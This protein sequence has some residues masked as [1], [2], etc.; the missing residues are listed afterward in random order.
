[1]IRLAVAGALGRMGR[2]VI[3]RAAQD[4]RFTLT[5]ALVAELPKQLDGAIPYETN[6]AKP[7]DVLIDFTDARGTRSWLPV[8]AERRIAMVIGTTGHDAADEARIREAAK[9]I[10]IVKAANFS[11]GIHLVARAV[12]ELAKQLGTDFDVEIVETHH[13]N[14]VD[15]PSGTALMLLDELFAARNQTRDSAV[16]G[17]EGHTGAR[18]KGQIGV[19]AV[20]FGDVVGRHEVH[21]SGAGETICVKHEAHSRDAFAAGALLAAAWVVGKP[22]GLYGMNSVVA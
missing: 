8:C 10:P 16:F 2:C 1:M 12:R 9:V 18:P 3:D 5:S 20:R 13:R 15:A 21:F 14:K 17:R 4:A 7:C 19:H 6:L 11:P 22:A